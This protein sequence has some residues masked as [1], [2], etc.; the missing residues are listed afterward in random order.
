MLKI[1]MRHMPGDI[2]L[3]DKIALM[4]NRPDEAL[5]HVCY[6]RANHAKAFRR[7]IRGRLRAVLKERTQKEIKDQMDLHPK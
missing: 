4:E 1:K 7:M 3:R 5:G 2:P 6:N